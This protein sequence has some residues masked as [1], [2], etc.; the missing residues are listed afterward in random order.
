MDPEGVRFVIAAT[1]DNYDFVE[2]QRAWDRA[3]TRK[4]AR[5]ALRRRQRAAV[6]ERRAARAWHSPLSSGQLRC[7]CAWCDAARKRSSHVPGCRRGLL[8]RLAVAEGRE[9]RFDADLS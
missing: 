8:R 2:P 6:V 1:H 5:V 7:E 4:G 3:T 9:A